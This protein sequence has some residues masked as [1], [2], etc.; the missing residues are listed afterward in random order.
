M[1]NIKQ[2]KRYLKG[3]VEKAHRRKR[4][5]KRAR[6]QHRQDVFDMYTDPYTGTPMHPSIA[7]SFVNMF[8][9]PM[10]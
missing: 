7:K 9:G 2:F 4:R 8:Y 5:K 10:E 3:G 1:M 6:N